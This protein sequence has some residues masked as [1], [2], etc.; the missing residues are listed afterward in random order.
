MRE[1]CPPQMVSRGRMVQDPRKSKRKIQLRKWPDLRSSSRLSSTSSGA[2]LFALASSSQLLASEPCFTD[3]ETSCF[4]PRTLGGTLQLAIGYVIQHFNKANFV[5]NFY[6]NSKFW[7]VCVSYKNRQKNNITVSCQLPRTAV[8]ILH[9]SLV[10]NR[11]LV[12]LVF[13]TTQNS[14][15]VLV[16][17]S[18][19]F[20]KRLAC[21][22]FN[23]GGQLFLL[24][25]QHIDVIGISME[26]MPGSLI[27]PGL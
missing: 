18:W 21:L 22:V 8:K 12:R 23:P 11:R 6:S 27:H 3:N 13:G 4:K 20:S 25:S 24:A 17:Q 9:Y 10:L 16:L 15:G 14:H 1:Q 19:L 7:Q 2:N 26:G 5:P